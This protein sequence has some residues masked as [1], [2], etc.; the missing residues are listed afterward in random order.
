M[1]RN[2][3]S[4]HFLI[5]DHYL[6]DGGLETALLFHERLPLPHF[7]AF[8]LLSSPELRKILDAYYIKY[9]ELAKCYGTGFIL[10]S[11]TWR[12]NPD[13][14]YKLG[15]SQKELV[16]ANQIAIEQ[17]K[18]LRSEYS[19]EIDSIL[20]SGCVGPRYDGYVAAVSE[21]WEDAKIY[22]S[23]QIKTFRDSG[24]D[25]V[26]GLTMTNVEEAMGIVMAAKDVRVPV[27][28]SFTVEVDGHLPDGKSLF[29]AVKTIDQASEDYPL[30]YMINCAHPVHFADRLLEYYQQAY[31]IQGIR[32]NASCK[33]HAELDE[34]TELDTGNKKQL[35]Q[36]YEILKSRHPHIK[37]FGGCCGTDISHM[38]EIC[39]AVISK[40]NQL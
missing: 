28:I 17:M 22:H 24:V 19:D 21:N 40:N 27:V 25:M 39:S 3:T 29:E 23:R 4:K 10:E 32:A 20:I 1:S 37:I 7:A 26:S 13:W 31:R 34:A 38:E 5:N 8:H 2:I 6:T 15:Y 36:W 12:A 33:S 30:Y 9:L 35:A 16:K 11:A 14:G 18:S